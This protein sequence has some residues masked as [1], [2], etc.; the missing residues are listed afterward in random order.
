MERTENQKLIS[1]TI[2]EVYRW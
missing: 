2:T 1:V